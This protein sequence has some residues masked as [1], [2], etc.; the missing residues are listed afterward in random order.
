M[1]G[2]VAW[3]PRSPVDPAEVRRRLQAALRAMKH[4]GPDD[5]GIAIVRTR[6]GI[7]VGLGNVRLAIQDTSPAG[8]QPMV[9]GDATLVLNGEIYNHRDLRADA[10]LVDFAFEGHSD[11]ET[12]L[13][14]WRAWQSDVFERLDG[15][16][17]LAV[18]DASD[19]SLTVGRD[20]LGIKPL[21]G[22]HGDFGV[23]VASELRALL[24]TGLVRREIDRE[25]LGGY[26]RFGCVPEPLTLIDGVHR[27]GAGRFARIRGGEVEP[28]KAYWSPLDAVPGDSVADALRA[29]VAS[30]LLSDVP[31][32]VLL[33]GGIDSSIVTALAAEA[34]PSGVTAFTVGFDE[35]RY[36]ETPWARKMATRYGLAHEV[37]RLTGA[38]V[39]EQIPAA[40]VD[41]DAPSV[42]G[43]NTWIVSKAIADAGFKVALTGLGGDE[44]FGG[45]ETFP[46]MARAERLAG[47][48]GWLPR[49]LRAQL[50]GGGERG[51]RSAELVARGRSRA[52]RYD[53]LRAF[54]SLDALSRLGVEQA[55]ALATWMPSGAM[56]TAS[57]T[58]LLELGGYMRSMLLRDADANSMA[59]SVE[60]RVPF[61]DHVLVGRALAS[62]AAAGTRHKQRLLGAFEHLLVEGLA[63]RPKQGFVLPMDEWMR[64]ALASHVAQGLQA[65]GAHLDRHDTIA[66]IETSWRAGTTRWTRVWALSTLGHW[67]NGMLQR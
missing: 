15:M 2:I 27:L 16:F 38:E 40:V 4:R 21:Y 17:T 51:A 43:F 26:L 20:R 46:R 64:G 29:S 11:T 53:T 5:E 10:A 59:H 23:I 1:C 37:V 65:I 35:S 14:G 22:A 48:I 61:L 49:G 24:A 25:G 50:G 58:S 33:S 62:N 63:T 34:A 31:V 28:S 19:D 55:P 6:A 54:W 56:A 3:Y 47:R 44:L 42:D 12:V 13:A 45:Y 18:F 41:M 9:R 30:H 36:D 52:D 66:S 60:L 32:A 7:P 8:H 67:L 39:V 57:A